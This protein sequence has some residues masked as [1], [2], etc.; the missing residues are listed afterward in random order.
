MPRSKCLF[1]NGKPV[2]M[3]DDV[4]VE[5][6][7]TYCNKCASPNE[8]FIKVS[9][10]IGLSWTKKSITKLKNVYNKHVKVSE[11][12]YNNIVTL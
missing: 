1:V 2:Q 11:F 9:Q 4:I 6:M 12:N 5:T 3:S 7:M 8:I 10:E